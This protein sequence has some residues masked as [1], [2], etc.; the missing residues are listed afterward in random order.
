MKLILTKSGIYFILLVISIFILPAC[1]KWSLPADLP[2]TYT[3]KERVVI[4]YD[5][6]GQFVYRDDIVMVSMTIDSKGEVTGMVGEADFEGC[7]VTQNRGWLSRQLGIKTDFIIRGKLTGSTIEKDSIIYKNISIPF[8]M[9]NGGLKGSLF[10]NNTG[11][12]YPIISNLKL[13]KHG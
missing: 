5:R 9:E 4:R 3:G 12:N 13:I 11:Q 6:E 7:K 10:L 8:N 1:G 2:G